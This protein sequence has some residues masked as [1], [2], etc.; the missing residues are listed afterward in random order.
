MRD[1]ND[2]GQSTAFPGND[3]VPGLG[4][5]DLR[6]FEIADREVEARNRENLYDFAPPEFYEG[7]EDSARVHLVSELHWSACHSGQNESYCIANSEN[8]EL[9]QATWHLVKH[10]AMPADFHPRP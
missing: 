5:V 1:A 3:H 8:C 4:F 10:T 6:M 7:P 2:D 9:E